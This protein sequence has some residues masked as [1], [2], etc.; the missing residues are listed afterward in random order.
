MPLRRRRFQAGKPV[1]G[2]GITARQAGRNDDDHLKPN[3]HLLDR[4]RQADTTPR[5]RHSRAIT[6]CPRIDP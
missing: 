2:P 3:L 5:R 6:G 1:C 4:I